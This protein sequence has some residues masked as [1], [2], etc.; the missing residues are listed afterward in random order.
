MFPNGG[1]RPRVCDG[2]GSEE[3]PEGDLELCLVSDN[4][5]QT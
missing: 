2:G 1:K 5:L 4:S 3:N